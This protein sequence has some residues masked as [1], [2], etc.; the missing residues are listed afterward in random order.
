M[1]YPYKILIRYLIVT[2]NK[3]Y[4]ETKNDKHFI[5]YKVDLLFYTIGA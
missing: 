3:I 1:I 5:N 2:I 4:F